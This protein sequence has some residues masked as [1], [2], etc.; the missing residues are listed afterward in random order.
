MAQ[1]STDRRRGINSSAAIKVA[2]ITASTA[3][4]TLSGEQTVDGIALLEANEDRVLCKDQTDSTENGIYEVSTGTWTRAPDFDGPFDVVEGTIVPVSRGTVNADTEFRVSNTGD[5]TIGTTALTFEARG[6][7]DSSS[8][9][10]LQAGT[11]AVSRT[12]ESKLRETFSVTDFGATGDGVTDDTASIQA[13]INASDRVYFPEGTYKITSTIDLT[14]PFTLYGDG[15]EST[16]LSFQ[17]MTGTTD[18]FDIQQAGD[19]TIN[20]MADMTI[21][22]KGANGRYAVTS[23][24]GTSVFN[25]NTP[26]YNFERLKFRGGVETATESLYDYGWSRYLDIGDGRN[27]VFRDIEIFGIYDFSVDPGTVT[28]DSTVGFFLSGVAGEGGVLTPI[29][30]HCFCHYVGISVQF[31]YQVSNPFV[32]NSQFHRG[33][34]GIYSPRTSSGSTYGVLEAQF[35]NLNINSQLSGIYVAQSAFM[36][37]DSVRVTRA[38]GGYDHAST[39]TGIHLENVDDLKML[40]T[41]AYVAGA[42]YTNTAVGIHLNTCD[43][44]YV[45]GYNAIENLDRGIIFEDCV[46]TTMVGS[47]YQAPSVSSIYFKYT[48]IALQTVTVIGDKHTSG[49]TPYSFDASVDRESVKIYA[50]K[51]IYIGGVNDTATGITA[52]G[53]T[54]DIDVDND[55]QVYWV[56][57]N[58]SASN[59]TFDLLN[60]N[61]TEGCVFKFRI[62]MTA[63]FTGLLSILPDGGG[64]I[65]SKTGPGSAVVYIV[66]CVYTE[67]AW[68]LL[69][70]Y[71]SD[72]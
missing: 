23:P 22:V 39:W 5:I 58:T 71:L 34:R 45:A 37:I 33:H 70:A 26:T 63:G 50:D 7:S 36:D 35:D 59:H 2:C 29:I 27:H 49:S 57:M 16:I 65:W 9:T 6:A 25:T 46:R 28:T 13:A 21:E 18:G 48:A 44:V 12:T 4:L 43:F 67:G 41:R 10:F 14:P 1:V 20:S 11:D 55:N 38:D 17:S 52:A 51:A 69:G 68:I 42:G 66:E 61:A 8:Q 62:Q 53:G 47:T 56:Q 24:R 19:R 40:G 31:D 3:N 32:T 30:D 54:D 72:A 60:A 64:A 15:A